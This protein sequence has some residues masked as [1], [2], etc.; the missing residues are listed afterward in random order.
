MSTVEIAKGNDWENTG[1]ETDRAAGR[2][3]TPEKLT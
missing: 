3:G 1:C 2:P